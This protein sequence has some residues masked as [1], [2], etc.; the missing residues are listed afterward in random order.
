MTNCGTLSQDHSLTHIE[1]EVTVCFE[2]RLACSGESQLLGNLTDY[3][4][5]IRVNQAYS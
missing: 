2:Y 3:V 5:I 1:V 4:A